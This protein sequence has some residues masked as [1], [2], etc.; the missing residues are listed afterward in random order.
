MMT[1]LRN[2]CIYLMKYLNPFS[3]DCFCYWKWPNQFENSASQRSFPL[4]SPTLLRSSLCRRPASTKRQPAPS[5]SPSTPAVATDPQNLFKPTCSAWRSTAPNSSCSPERLP[6]PRRETALWV[7][8]SCCHIRLN[9]QKMWWIVVVVQTSM[10]CFGR[11]LWEI[12]MFKSF[13]K[14]SL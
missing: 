9:A 5:A 13:L 1:N 12:Q 2:L 11:S 4:Q 14:G 10:L 6:R 3:D 8:L 7:S